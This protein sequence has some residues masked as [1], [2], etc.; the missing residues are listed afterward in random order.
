[1]NKIMGDY[2]NI[3]QSDRASNEDEDAEGEE[4]AGEAAKSSTQ[5][6]DRNN[7]NASVEKRID[8]ASEC[9]NSSRHKLD[10][11]EEEIE[12]SVLNVSGSSTTRNAAKNYVSGLIKGFY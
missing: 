8:N 4:T 5:R 7:H 2:S 3:M 10:P 1:M 6:A 12:N 9:S 11:D